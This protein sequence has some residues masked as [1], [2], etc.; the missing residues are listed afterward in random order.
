MNFEKKFSF[1]L[2]LATEVDKRVKETS[3]KTNVNGKIFSGQICSWY[4]IRE[5]VTGELANSPENMEQVLF[6]MSREAFF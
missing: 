6:F 4:R 5:F 1:V 3:I 2:N